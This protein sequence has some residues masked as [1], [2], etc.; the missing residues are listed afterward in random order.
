MWK[1]DQTHSEHI[2]KFWHYDILPYASIKV[3]IFWKSRREIDA[4][5]L[6]TD[7][8]SCISGCYCPVGLFEDHNGGCVTHENCT[9]EFS[10]R[11]YETGQSVETNCK[12]W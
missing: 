8:N 3:F 1:L 9:C 11:V 10:G 7:D 4:V 2:S 6:Q 12:I 5:Y